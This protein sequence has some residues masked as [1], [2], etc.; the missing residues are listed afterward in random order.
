MVRWG[1]ALGVSPGRSATPYELAEAIGS[2]LPEVKSQACLVAEAYAGER[3][4]DR[5]A[6]GRSV[7][8]A[9]AR[10]RWPFARAWIAHRVAL[11]VPRRFSRSLGAPSGA[12]RGRA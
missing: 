7:G 11:A 12:A 5:P 6:D 4:G 9:W 8:E 10:L 3:Y 2:R 1:H